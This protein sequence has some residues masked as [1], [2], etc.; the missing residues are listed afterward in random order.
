MRIS[1]D[2]HHLLFS[3]ASVPLC[4]CS[5]PCRQRR[6]SAPVRAA[7]DV[8]ALP[9]PAIPL[10]V[11]LGRPA[12]PVSFGCAP[13]GAKTS[14][15]VAHRPFRSP[16]RTHDRMKST[17][18]RRAA[19]SRHSFLAARRGRRLASAD[20]SP[21]RAAGAGRALRRPLLLWPVWSRLAR[22]KAPAPKTPNP[23]V[24]PVRFALWTLRDEAAQRRS[25]PR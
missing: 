10:S 7:V 1:T 16:C 6:L 25:P 20:F 4:L 9:I 3:A 13:E 21:S 12:K 17:V 22:A 14:L 15:R 19:L 23:A 18:C 11:V 8:A 5:S 2:H 24:D